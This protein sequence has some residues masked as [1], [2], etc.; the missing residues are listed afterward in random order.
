MKN[1]IEYK[2]LYKL[3]SVDHLNMK[4]NWQYKYL[5]VRKWF[6]FAYVHKSRPITKS[7]TPIFA[8]AP[9]LKRAES[10][11]QFHVHISNL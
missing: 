5:P 1:C 8:K 4:Q 11:F 9:D 6:L 2:L 7:P 3:K 10:N